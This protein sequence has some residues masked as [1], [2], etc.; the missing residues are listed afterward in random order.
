MG[1][2]VKNIASKVGR[3]FFGQQTVFESLIAEDREKGGGLQVFGDDD[4][5]ESGKNDKS[6]DVDDGL[7][8][9]DTGTGKRALEGDASASKPGKIPKNSDDDLEDLFID[10]TEAR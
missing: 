1:A 5:K 2:H 4:E 7:F 10:D 6:P 9:E 3:R 8:V